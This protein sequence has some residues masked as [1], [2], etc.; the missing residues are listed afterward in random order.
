ML[1]RTNDASRHQENQPK[2]RLFFS[3]LPIILLNSLI[4]SIRLYHSSSSLK[5]IRAFSRERLSIMKT[6]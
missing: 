6:P 1:K 5:I 4:L 3:L 2:R